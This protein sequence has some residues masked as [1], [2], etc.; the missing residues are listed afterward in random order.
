MMD[1]SSL[2]RTKSYLISN[3]PGLW[4]YSRCR[5]TKYFFWRYS[6]EDVNRRIT[7]SLLPD[8]VKY[9]V[10]EEV[11]PLDLSRLEAFRGE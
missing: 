3:H 5:G 8:E 4:R 7:L 1:C 9:H 10:W 2:N 11:Q 6:N